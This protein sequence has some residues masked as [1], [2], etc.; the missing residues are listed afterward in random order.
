MSV[1]STLR[2]LVLG[3]TWTL[4][5]GITAVVLVAALVV[6][7][8]LHGGWEHAGGFVLLGGLCAALILS[9]SLSA[10]KRR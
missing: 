3:E 8:A 2:K 1:L 9:V 10:G 6:R 7:P 5:V 4:P